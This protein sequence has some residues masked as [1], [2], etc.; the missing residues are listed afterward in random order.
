[1]TDKSLAQYLIAKKVAEVGLEPRSVCLWRL[2][3]QPSSFILPLKEEQNI[4][5]HR[6]VSEIRK[7]YATANSGYLG[8]WGR[9]SF[10]L[11]LYIILYCLHFPNEHMYAPQTH[12]QKKS[13]ITVAFG[14]CLLSSCYVLCPALS[15]SYSKLTDSSQLC[16][17]GG[18]YR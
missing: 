16:L 11:L 18:Y 10:H 5:A 13:Q 14:P 3:S 8:S 12:T 17:E 4:C 7:G 9:V 6:H 15:T 2:N 1:L